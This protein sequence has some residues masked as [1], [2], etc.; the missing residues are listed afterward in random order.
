MRASQE[1]RVEELSEKVGGRFRLTT[2]VQK[3]MR[4]YLR[5][6]RTFMPNVKN[7][8]ELFDYILDEIEDGKI[9]L[10][11]PK[12]RQAEEPVLGALEGTEQSETAVGSEG[13]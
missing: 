7:V 2:L 6:G 5:A 1:G 3:Q 8:D 12:G 9:Q 11:P 13:E 4:D 10:L